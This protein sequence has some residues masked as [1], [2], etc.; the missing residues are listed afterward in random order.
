[1]ELLAQLNISSCIGMCVCRYNNRLHSIQAY[2]V[3][4]S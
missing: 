2:K 3:A 4:D 1:M